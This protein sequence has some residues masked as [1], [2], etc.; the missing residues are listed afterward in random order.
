MS[1]VCTC[2]DPWFDTDLQGRDYPCRRCGGIVPNFPDMLVEREPTFKRWA[3]GGPIS[4]HL[5]FETR[6]S[7]PLGDMTQLLE[8]GETIVIY[9][10]D[11]SGE[12]TVRPVEPSE[13]GSMDFGD[14]EE[15]VL[16]YTLHEGVSAHN[17]QLETY[18]RGLVDLKLSYKHDPDDGHFDNRKGRRARLAEIRKWRRG[19]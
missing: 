2:A 18:A 7:M 19:R 5:D 16:A 17:R 1:E 6:S 15:R 14:L 12:L 11:E 13:F 10:R 9:A 3:G 8:S 4:A